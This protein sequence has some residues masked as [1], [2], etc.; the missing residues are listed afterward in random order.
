M[1]R[2]DFGMI[3]SIEAITSLIVGKGFSMSLNGLPT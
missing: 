1:V 3:E 2:I